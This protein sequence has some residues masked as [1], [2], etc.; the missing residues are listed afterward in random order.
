MHRISFS[1]HSICSFIVSIMVIMWAGLYNVD[2]VS[3]VSIFMISLLFMLLM[4]FS[5]QNPIIWLWGWW[6]FQ[7]KRFYYRQLSNG[8]RVYKVSD[9]VRQCMTKKQMHKRIS[10]RFPN[11]FMDSIELVCKQHHYRKSEFV[12]EAI[13]RF[14]NDL[15]ASG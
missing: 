9:I 13:R 1:T 11:D 5:S 6:I 7:R 12:R 10:V 14:I 3:S 8:R 4:I 15:S 2:K